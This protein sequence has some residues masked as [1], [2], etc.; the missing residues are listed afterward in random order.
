MKNI[1]EHVNKQET[2]EIENYT[3]RFQS[4]S[5]AIATTIPNKFD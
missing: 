5:V 4:C 2:F 3:N 1:P